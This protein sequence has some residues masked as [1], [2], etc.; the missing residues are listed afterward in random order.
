ME[1]EEF[2][3]GLVGLVILVGLYFLPTA[4]AMNRKAKRSAGITLLNLFLGWTFIGWV[5][6]LIWA[7]SDNTTGPPRWW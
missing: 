3:S 5:G 2:A 1:S 6:A 7:V 4:I